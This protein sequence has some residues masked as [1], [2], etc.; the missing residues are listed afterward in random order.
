MSSSSGAMALHGPHHSA[1]KSTSTGVSDCST[2][3]SNS[4]SLT[5]VTCSLM[6]GSWF[7]RRKGMAQRWGYRG[8]FASPAGNT[9]IRYT[10]RNHGGEPAPLPPSSAVILR[11]SL[12]QMPR[13]PFSR[14][15]GLRSEPGSKCLAIMLDRK[16]L[17]SHPWLHFSIGDRQRSRG[18]MAEHVLTDTFFEQFDLHPLLA[19]GLADCGF[20]RCT[21][22]QAL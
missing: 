17:N 16:D 14:Q 20:T 21:P 8:I 19:Q 12:V 15:R 10:Y 1:Q 18:P 13:I 4:S 2:W 11:A 22:I 6:G 3:A 9:G 5:W 7:V